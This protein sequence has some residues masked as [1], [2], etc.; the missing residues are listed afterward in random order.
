MK[1]ITYSLNYRKP[2]EEYNDDD[3]LTV[4]VRYYHKFENGTQKVIKKSTGVKC[5]LKDWDSDWHKSDNRHPIKSSDPEYLEKNRLIRNKSIDLHSLIKDL[6]PLQ[7]KSLLKSNIPNGPLDLKW[8]NHKNNV[9]LVSPA[10]KRNIDVIVVGTGLAGGSASATLAEQ[11]YNVK[12]FVF[13]T[14]PGELILLQHKVVL[15]LL[16]IIRVM[17]TQ[18]TDYFMILSKEVIT[19]LERLMFID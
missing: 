3:S 14:H 16:K 11:G 4:C 17:V 2:K 13:K 1:K 5:K 12:A 9:R 6:K 10:N 7:S 8:S 19:D 18:F 15:T